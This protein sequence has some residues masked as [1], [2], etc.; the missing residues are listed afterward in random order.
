MLDLVVASSPALLVLQVRS[1]DRALEYHGNP[2][3]LF[4]HVEVLSQVRCHVSLP[5]VLRA[6]LVHPVKVALLVGSCG[7]R[8]GRHHPGT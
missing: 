3:L 1:T 7:G 6:A 5:L 8:R 4:H 2:L